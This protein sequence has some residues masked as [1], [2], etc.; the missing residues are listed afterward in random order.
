M[1]A[2]LN[3]QLATVQRLIAENKEKM[4]ASQEKYERVADEFVEG[5]MK[6]F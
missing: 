1:D 4:E 3:A 2:E 5:Y 6:A